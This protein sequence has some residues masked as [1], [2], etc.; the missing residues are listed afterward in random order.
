MHMFRPCHT[1][2]RGEY[3]IMVVFIWNVYVPSLP[4][5]KNVFFFLF[6]LCVCVVQNRRPEQQHVNDLGAEKEKRQNRVVHWKCSVCL[7]IRWHYFATF[8]AAKAAGGCYLLLPLPGPGCMQGTAVVQVCRLQ[9]KRDARVNSY[10]WSLLMERKAFDKVCVRYSG[11]THTLILGK[12]NITVSSVFRFNSHWDLKIII[13]IWSRAFHFI[14]FLNNL[15]LHFN[16]IEN[17]GIQPL[18]FRIIAANI[19]CLV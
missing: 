6:S 4:G 8:P 19:F 10:L 2:G 15:I 11:R 17:S 5:K 16:V 1:Q 3:K 14:Q 7:A 18:A 13:K 12:P 9:M